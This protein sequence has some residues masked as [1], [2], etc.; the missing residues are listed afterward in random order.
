MTHKIIFRNQGTN[1]TSELKVDAKTAKTAAQ[2]MG[3]GK[4]FYAGNAY[5]RGL[6][7]LKV[8]A[9]PTSEQRLTAGPT[10]C[11]KCEKGW[12]PGP[13]GFSPCTCNALGRANV[14]EYRASLIRQG[15]AL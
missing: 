3:T 11:G 5:L 2:F 15:I 14:D 13:R 12:V 7:V 8:E 1:E 9:L 4:G 10:F 6:D